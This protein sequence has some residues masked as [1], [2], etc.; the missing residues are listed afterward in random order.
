[1]A[2]QPPATIS[3]DASDLSVVL[4]ESATTDA[5]VT[6]TASIEPV[7]FD[8][9]AGSANAAVHAV[10]SVPAVIVGGTLN[11]L[12][13]VRS[14]APARIPVYVLETTRRCAAAWSRYGRFVRVPSLEGHGLIEALTT[15]A[16]QLRERP[17]LILTSDESVVTVSSARQQLEPLYRVS[18]PSPE[19][20]EALADKTAFHAFA[21]HAGLTVPRGVTVDCDAR[22]SL[23]RGLTPPI[24]I[25]PA[26]KVLVLSGTVERAVR[27]ETVT[28]A[29][30]VAARMLRRAPR[31]IVQEWIHGPDTEIF[32]TLFT[33]DRVSRLTG[34]FTGRKIVCSPPAFGS[35]A[36][37]VAAPEVAGELQ[38]ET[39]RFIARTSYRGLGSLEFKRDTRN[40]RF[41]IIEPTVGRTDWQEEI[42]TLCG[43]NLP[44]IA[45]RTELG[46]ATASAARDRAHSITDYA[47]VAW[48]S[49]REFRAPR[50]TGAP[51]LRM[52][53]GYLRWSDPL[54]ALYH[55][56]YERLV[57]R[58]WGRV[59][60]ARWHAR[61]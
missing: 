13:V 37:C 41:L 47:A 27:A 5:S 44:L 15:L 34:L 35:T 53:D 46:Q 4:D 57:R 38:A 20:V 26:D 19:M 51:P 28:E 60:A 45:Y 40:G 12:G 58:V 61:R 21:E 8:V 3:P 23:I 1:M 2:L 59:T 36:V 52:V 11:S 24:V 25:K 32:F 48:R 6:P 55:Y 16:A 31:L 50:A 54:P 49:S 9:P 10:P 14:L 22:L 39:L 29:E 56:G 7:E 18:L 30:R 42:A 43:V 17:V 33:C